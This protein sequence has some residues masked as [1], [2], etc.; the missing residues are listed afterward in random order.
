MQW[1]KSCVTQ[2]ISLFL[3]R[4]QQR[5]HRIIDRGIIL[6][7]RIGVRF[8]RVN[9]GSVGGCEIILIPFPIFF[10]LSSGVLVGCGGGLRMINL[11]L[12]LDSISLLP[13]VLFVLRIDPYLYI[14]PPSIVK[15]H[16]RAIRDKSCSE[17]QYAVAIK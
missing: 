6:G 4:I 9:G 10:S 2:Q 8:G 11:P 15:F 5:Y 14:V 3:K 7:R 13:L 12:L 1:P 16:F 17:I